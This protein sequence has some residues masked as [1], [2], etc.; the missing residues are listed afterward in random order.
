M[1]QVSPLFLSPA[2]V[3][4]VDHTAPSTWGTTD[5]R[6]SL[7][8]LLNAEISC[9]WPAYEMTWIC[10]LKDKLLFKTVNVHESSKDVMKTRNFV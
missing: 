4:H 5:K 3:S 8:L 1:S 10:S 7:R 2:S 6:I 9:T